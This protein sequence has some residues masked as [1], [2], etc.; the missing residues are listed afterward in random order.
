MG[1]LSLTNFKTEEY[2]SIT[3]GYWMG[4]EYAGKGYMKDS[5][6]VISNYCFNDLKLNRIEAACLPKNLI[7]KRVLLNSGFKKEGY[8]KKY[9]SIN[10]KLEDH[11]LLAK[12]K[13]G[14]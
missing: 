7:S 10:G 2:K 1:G 13:K 4:E 3:M 14:V 9:L 5:L 12:I 6:K 11:L 8:A